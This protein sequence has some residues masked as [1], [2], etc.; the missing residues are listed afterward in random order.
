[1]SGISTVAGSKRFSAD[2]GF[3]ISIPQQFSYLKQPRPQIVTHEVPNLWPSLSGQERI[4]VSM[5]VSAST[6]DGTFWS[7]CANNGGDPS[8]GVKT[9][10]AKAVTVR[11]RAVITGMNT[12]STLTVFCPIVVRQ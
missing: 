6:I 5:I 11:Y 3:L 12:S 2:V 4:G 9:T 8:A 10:R 7:G 1:M